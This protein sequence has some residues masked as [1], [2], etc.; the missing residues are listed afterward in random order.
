[1]K[2]KTTAALLAFFL[3][4]LGIHHFYLNSGKGIWYLLFFWT[5]IPALIAFIE[6]IIFLTMDQQEFDRRYNTQSSNLN[7][8]V[9]AIHITNS[10]GNHAPNVSNV[11]EELERLFNLKEKGVITDAEFQQQK[12]KLI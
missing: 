1:M 7:T 2:N 6:S 4:G 12:A 9:P 8:P 5:L 10:Y 11:S 3:G